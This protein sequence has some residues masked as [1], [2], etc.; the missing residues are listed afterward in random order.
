M[1]IKSEQSGALKE[2]TKRLS[3]CAFANTVHP[4]QGA[5][6][7][8][9]ELDSGRLTGRSHHLSGLRIQHCRELWCRSQMQL[10]SLIAV[11]VT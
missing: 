9:L 10:G 4:R 7:W 5:H 2:G 8:L 6:P 3:P 1:P 11:A